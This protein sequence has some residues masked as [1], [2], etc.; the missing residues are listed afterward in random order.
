[1]AQ[2]ETGRDLAAIYD[3]RF[4]EAERLAKR[5]IWEVL[6]REFFQQF[7]PP[8]ST[9]LDL[10]C[11]FGE[12]SSFIKAKRKFAVDMNPEVKRYLPPEVTFWN[13]SAD[14]LSMLPDN[15]IDVCFTSNFFE[16]LPS[17]SVMNSVLGEVKRVLKPSGR[18]V[19]LQPNIRY[20]SKEYW[21]FYDHYT[22]L[23]HLSCA[24]GFAKAGFEIERLIPR[25]LPY[26]TKSRLP[27][28]PA[29][30]S[31]YL[32]VPLMWKLLGKQFVIVGRKPLL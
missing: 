20:V 19:A 23:S 11:G 7:V 16:H 31:A 32:K 25:F 10:A 9:I 15:E 2:T 18:F 27:Q 8:D 6:C 1:M 14:S 24:E 3:Y 4:S 5:Q 30:V 26:T 17:K 28:S 29:L 12:F 13:S 22:P 21:D